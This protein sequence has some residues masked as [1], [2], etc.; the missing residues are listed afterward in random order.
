MGVAADGAAWGACVCVAEEDDDGA[1]LAFVVAGDFGAAVF[2]FLGVSEVEPKPFFAAWAITKEERC[3]VLVSGAVVKHVTSARLA[4]NRKNEN[5]VL[6]I[7]DISDLTL[8]REQ[9]FQHRV[10]RR[11]TEREKYD[12]T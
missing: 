4:K 6:F 12:G 10:Q 2:F 5:A 1:G 3:A 9:L 11:E 8:S 7:V